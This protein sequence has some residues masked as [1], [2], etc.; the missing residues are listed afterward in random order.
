LLFG[1][2]I[3]HQEM[4]LWVQFHLVN[5]FISLYLIF[6]SSKI[7]VSE[8]MKV[9]NEGWFKL[10]SQEE[11]DFYAVPVPSEEGLSKAKPPI[12][13]CYYSIV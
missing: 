13:V 12:K 5:N 2:G 6:Y 10:L 3:E 8:L 9:S 4:I 11:G 1:I 7:G